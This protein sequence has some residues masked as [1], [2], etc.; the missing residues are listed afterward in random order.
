ML[1]CSSG[2]IVVPLKMAE[3]DGVQGMRYVPAFSLCVLLL[4]TLQLGVSRLVTGKPIQWHAQE[5]LK[6]GLSSGTFWSIGNIGSVYASLSPLGQTTGFPLTQVRPC[7]C[8]PA[9][10]IWAVMFCDCVAGCSVSSGYFGHRFVQRSQRS[11]P[12][13][14]FLGVWCNADDRCGSVGT[15]WPVCCVYSACCVNRLNLS[16]V[17][18]VRLEF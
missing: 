6:P 5:A 3:L 12:C 18:C 7:G 1:S 10:M 4:A 15:E 16:A 17:C 8:Y 9:A 14:Q 2:S 11:P 13:G